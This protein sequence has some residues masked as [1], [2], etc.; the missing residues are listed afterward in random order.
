MRKA[1]DNSQRI[2]ITDTI[3]YACETC[4]LKDSTQCSQL[5]KYA[6]SAASEDRSTASFY[7][8]KIGKTYSSVYIQRRLTEKGLVISQT[9]H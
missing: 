7:G 6:I 8:F 1:L 2:K 3:D 4:D 5:L 9:V